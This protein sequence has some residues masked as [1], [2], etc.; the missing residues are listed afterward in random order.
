MSAGL[1]EAAEYICEGDKESLK[2]R[3]LKDGEIVRPAKPETDSPSA[4]DWMA[5]FLPEGK[6]LALN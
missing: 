2:I 5:D 1:L 6:K 4:P 3:L